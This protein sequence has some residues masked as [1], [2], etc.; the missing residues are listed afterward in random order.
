MKVS[1]VE[2]NA[3]GTG[4]NAMAAV[5]SSGMAWVMGVVVFIVICFILFVMVKHFRRLIYGIVT[6]VPF[7]LIGWFSYGIASP[8]KEGNWSPFFST[9]EVVLGIVVLIAIGMLIEHFD[10]VKRLEKSIG[11]E[12]ENGKRTKKYNN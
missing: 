11:I 7:S 4:F 9:V 2:L 8:I 12:V 5:N 6:V 1:K 3:T 10:I